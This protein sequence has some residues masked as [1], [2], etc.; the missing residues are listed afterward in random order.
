M[1]MNIQEA[2]IVTNNICNLKCIYCKVDEL[3]RKTL[4]T[5]DI[6]N[7]INELKVLNFG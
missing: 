7:L 1:T 2:I 6:K 4:S 5:K 3:S